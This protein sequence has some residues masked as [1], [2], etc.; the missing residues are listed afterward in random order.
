MSAA[1][2]NCPARS[3][4]IGQRFIQRIDAFR[5]PGDDAVRRV[6]LDSA[7]GQLLAPGAGLGV[8]IGGLLSLVFGVHQRQ[9]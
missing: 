9:P 6:A 7:R 8:F 5:R 3:F 1:L 2:A 4:R